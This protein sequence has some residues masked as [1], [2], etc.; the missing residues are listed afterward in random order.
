MKKFHKQMIEKI[1]ELENIDKT[2]QEAKELIETLTNWKILYLSDNYNS[3]HMKYVLDSIQEERVDVDIMLNRLDE[4][5]NFSDDSN[6][7]IEI[8][9]IGRTK[10]RYNI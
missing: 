2:I 8:E 1:G 7:I 10:D 5:F 6:S 4:I 3:R 9:K